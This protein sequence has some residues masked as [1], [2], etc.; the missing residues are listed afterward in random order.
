MRALFDRVLGMSLAGSWVILLV[1]PARLALRK[2][3]A[4]YR[5]FLWAMVLLRLLCPFSPESR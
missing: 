2:T 1:L 4:K 3:P 5:Y